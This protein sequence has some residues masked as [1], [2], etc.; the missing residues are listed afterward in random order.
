MKILLF[1]SAHL[2]SDKVPQAGQ[3]I[4]LERIQEYSEEGY[5]IFLLA[6][7]NEVEQD[8]LQLT[9]FK[10]MAS[11]KLIC[12]NTSTRLKSICLH[13]LLPYR[14]ASR[15]STEAEKWIKQIVKDNKIDLIHFEFTTATFYYK[16]FE[17]NI[18]KIV[19]EHDILFQSFER[20]YRHSNPLKSILM[21]LEMKRQKRW[22]LKMLRSMDSII[23]LNKKD[24][25]LLIE[26]NIPESK[27]LVRIPKVDEK[28]LSVKRRNV[29]KGLIMFWGAMNRIENQD[30]IAWFLRSIFPSI[31]KKIESIQLVIVGTDPPDWLINYTDGSITVTGYVDDPLPWFEKAA[32]SIVPLRMGAGIKIKVLE[33]IAARI[34]IVSTDIGAEG[35]DSDLLFIANDPESFASQ[36][37]KLV[38]NEGTPHK[39]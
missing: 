28:Y 21:L 18:Y 14:V 27:I 13:P 32:V 33:C 39:G 22:E 2:P 6:F 26:E 19:V 7:V 24:K 25:K 3:K 8:Y 10:N 23:V 1:I 12:I 11:V 38:S 15:Y 31:K 34:P 9:N 16:L 5:T 30:A 29:Q 35:I 20:K 4:A 36:V 37:C 17:S